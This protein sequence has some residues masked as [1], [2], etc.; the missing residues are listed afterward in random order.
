MAIILTAT[1]DGLVAIIKVIVEKQYCKILTH[2][3]TVSHFY[4]PWTGLKWV[5]KGA[6]IMSY[7]QNENDKKKI[8]MM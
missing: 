8:R 1:L 3:S 5:N 7:S 6:Y 4:T 2:F